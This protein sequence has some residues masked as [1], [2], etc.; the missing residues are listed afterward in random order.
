MP[1]L[2]TGDNVEGEGG[3]VFSF[4]MILVAKTTGE[5]TSDDGFAGFICG[6]ALPGHADTV[7]WEL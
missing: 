6:M 4:H 7:Q 1:R 5:N 2:I 3:A